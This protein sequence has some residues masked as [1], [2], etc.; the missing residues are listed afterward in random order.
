MPTL[1]LK[2]EHTFGAR[3]KASLEKGVQK[4]VDWALKIGPRK[5]KEFEKIEIMKNLPR[6]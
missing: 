1:H 5:S 2:V 3:A 4:M 6:S